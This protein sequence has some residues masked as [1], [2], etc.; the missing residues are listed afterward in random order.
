MKNNPMD[1]MFAWM[2]IAT[3]YNMMMLSAGEVIARRTMMMASGAMTGPEAIRYDEGG[4]DTSPRPASACWQ[5][6]PEAAD[7]ARDRAPALVAA[8][9]RSTATRSNARKL[10]G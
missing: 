3:S 2:K 4:D 6:D 7:P 5:V 10:R 1:M 8:L 9:V